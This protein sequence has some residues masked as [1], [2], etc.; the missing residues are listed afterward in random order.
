MSIKIGVPTHKIYDSLIERFDEFK[1]KYDIQL[2][3]DA[4]SRIADLFANRKLDIAMLTPAGYAKGLAIAD[5]RI[6]PEACLAHE[7]FTG[8]LSMFFN[9]ASNRFKVLSVNDEHEFLTMIV[10]M[11]LAERYDSFP[12]VKVIKAPL[13]D[14]ISNSDIA[15]LHAENTGTDAALDVSEQWFDSFE[16]PLPLGLWVCRNEEL[17]EDIVRQIITSI[18]A[19]DAVA[20][21]HIEENFNVAGIDYLREGNIHYEWNDDIRQA[22]SDTLQMLFV[23]Q[24]IND[25]PEVKVLGNSASELPIIE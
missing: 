22:L 23:S 24:Y 2:F 13:E 4:E 16:F 1:A 6:I 12:E 19:E 3:R 5:Y 7:E 17:E 20:E 14:M 10:R 11:I 25:I 9:P 18:K 21:L 8:E 15:A